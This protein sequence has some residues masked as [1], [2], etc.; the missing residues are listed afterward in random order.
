MKGL[1]L[2][3]EVD[4]LSAVLLMEHAVEA[5]AWTLRVHTDVVDG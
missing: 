2:Q 5:S 3:M 4:M 1:T